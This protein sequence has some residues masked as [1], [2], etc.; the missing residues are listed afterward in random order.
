MHHYFFRP[1]VLS[2][3][4]LSSEQRRNNAILPR[5]LVLAWPPCRVSR[6][7]GPSG[8]GCLEPITCWLLAAGCRTQQDT[9]LS[10]LPGITATGVPIYSAVWLVKMSPKFC[11]NF[12]KT[13]RSCKE[14][15]EGFKQGK[16]PSLNIVLGKTWLTPNKFRLF[17]IKCPKS[18][19]TLRR[20]PVIA[21]QLLRW[22]VATLG[23]IITVIERE[24][25]VILLKLRHF[26]HTC[27]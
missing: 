24:A 1:Y 10:T 25:V 22:Q 3:W 8:R 14:V 4:Y 12:H 17:S 20:S 7:M 9:T 21:E 27:E 5:K 15:L 13:W 16:A 19:Y 26:S 2:T 23:F 11:S 18:H 6:V